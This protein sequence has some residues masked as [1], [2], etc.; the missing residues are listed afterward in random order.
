MVHS[1]GFRVLYIGCV[2]EGSRLV[3][4]RRRLRTAERGVKGLRIRIFGLGSWG[5]VLSRA[6]GL[7]LKNEI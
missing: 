4:S 6:Q 5:E 3:A 7:S 1:M 2:V